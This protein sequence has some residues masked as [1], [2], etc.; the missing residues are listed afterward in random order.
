[1]QE[2]IHFYHINDL[3]SHFEYWPRIRELLVTRKKW[4]EEV[5]DGCFLFD[6]G[7]N[8][9][10]SNIYTEATLGK[11]NVTLMNEGLYDAVTIGNN[12]GITLAADDLNHL[13]DD[14]KFDVILA[15]LRTKDGQLP[16]WAEPYHIYHTSQGT[17]VGVIAATAPFVSYYNPLGWS[18]EEPRT[19]LNTLAKQLRDQVDIL[20]CLSHLG[21]PEDE[22]LAEESPEIDVIFGSHTHHVLHE[23]KVVFGTL[24]TGG[25][26][27]GYFVGHTELVFDHETR[28]IT[29]KKTELYRTSDL[30]SVTGDTQFAEELALQGRKLLDVPVF[31]TDCYYNKEWYHH[32]NLSR[33]FAKGLL[34]FSGAE[35][36][37]FNAGIFLTDLQK[38][39]VTAYDI[40]KMLP[41]PINACIIDITGQQLKDALELANTK[42]ELPRIEVKGLGFRGSVM[43]KML[44]YG[45]SVDAEGQLIVNKKKADLDKSYKLVTLDMFT[46]GYFFPE[47]KELPITYLLPEFLRDIL[48]S[49]GHTYFAKDKY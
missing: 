31:Y 48:I 26:K 27:F 14:A 39:K 44:S 23:G 32:S 4:H 13:Y 5:G 11:G 19:V 16:D 2:T 36:A 49:Y 18:I 8:I 34:K 12:E 35:C 20:V 17:S 45:C 28:N 25:G 30:P 1:M 21:L 40:H 37:L 7:D 33:L 3:H 43:G 29:S 41:H 6:I 47:F 10:R 24:L 9:D 15:N 46:F 42:Q 22:K 38:G